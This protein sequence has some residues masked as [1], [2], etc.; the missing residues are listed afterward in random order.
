M[1]GR[2]GTSKLTLILASVKYPTIKPMA[3]ETIIIHPPILGYFQPSAKPIK[4]N[5]IIVSATFSHKEYP[6]LAN[7]NGLP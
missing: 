4:T 1:P 5:G 2:T 3:I 7:G 6:G